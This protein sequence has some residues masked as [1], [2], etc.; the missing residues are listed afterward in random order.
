MSRRRR[1]QQ[2]EAAG[3]LLLAVI[4]GVL[5]IGFVA[6]GVA[7]AYPQGTAVVLVV[8]TF[9]VILIFSLLG[10]ESKRGCRQRKRVGSG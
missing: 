6:I 3:N 10:A 9:F 5:M 4:L 8:A 1:R 7:T 2:D